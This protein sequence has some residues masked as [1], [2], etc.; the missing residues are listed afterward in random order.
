[1][2]R[3][4]A[5]TALT[6]SAL[7]MSGCAGHSANPLPVGAAA[8]STIEAKADAPGEDT[9][10]AGDHLAIRVLGEPELTSDAY[11]VDAKGKI[12]VP[13]AGEILVAGRNP[14]EVREELT[15]RLGGRYIRNPQVAVIV[16]ERR[17]TTFAVEG[18]V[19]EPGIFEAAPGT[20]L[21]SAVAQAKSTTD[22]AKLDEVMIFR[23]L[24]GQRIGARFNIGDIRGGRAADPVILAGDTVVVGRS[25]LKNGWK[26]F[27]QAVP[28]FNLFY[29]FKR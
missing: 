22:T 24:D 17:R 28:L 2:F 21:L 8:Y 26:Q 18:D 12:Q 15:R 11:V 20:T 10:R 6:L 4:A 1:M 19:R 16:S 25:G 7:A 5:P 13:L 9:I 3:F 23:M 27:L 14:G 29:I